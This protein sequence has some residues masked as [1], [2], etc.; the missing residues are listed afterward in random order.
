[1]SDIASELTET[2]DPLA[3]PLDI[4][5]EIPSDL[6]EEARNIAI[7]ENP[8]NELVVPSIPASKNRLALQTGKKWKP[9]RTLRVKFL[10][11]DPRVQ[12]KVAA[13]AQQWSQYANIR[14]SFGNH[15]K[16][17][18]RISFQ[19]KGHW[20]TNGTDALLLP[21]NQPTMNYEGLTPNTPDT[22]YTRVVL[23]EFGHVLGCIHEHLHPQVSI[24]W[25]KDAVYRSYMGAP[26]HWT[27]E[28][29]D[30][31]LFE[32]YDRTITQF[33]RFDPKS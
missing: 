25:N 4:C 32:K 17:E 30:H 27:K 33:S 1:M 18:I 21:Q 29:I 14:F 11:G 5:I 26:N 28:Q 15:P 12:Q 22:E 19:Q 6:S 31:N 16:A 2:V 24:P 23:H 10:D 3:T 9:G 7:A 20:S 8:D 13:I